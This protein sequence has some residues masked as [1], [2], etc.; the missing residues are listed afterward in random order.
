MNWHLVGEAGNAAKH[1]TVPR[2]APTTKD[3]LA[4]RVISAVVKNPSPPGVGTSSTEVLAEPE[5]YRQGSA[6]DG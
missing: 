1:P 6:G 3:R 5:S 4:P 2:T